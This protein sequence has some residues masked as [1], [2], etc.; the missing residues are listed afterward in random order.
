MIFA[1]IASFTRGWFIGDFQPALARVSEF[2]ACY[3]TF[4][5]GE[6]ERM[7][8]QGRSTEITLVVHGEILVNGKALVEGD[9]CMVAPGEPADFLAV[10]DCK[11]V[12][13]KF[14]SVPNDKVEV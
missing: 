14:P 9:L 12:G 7:S 2:E 10:T 1:K 4:K 8:V 13:I 5:A 11:V 6:S 3:K